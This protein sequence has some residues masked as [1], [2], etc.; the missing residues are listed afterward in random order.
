MVEKLQQKQT[1]TIDA[2]ERKMS[3][4]DIDVRIAPL[5]EKLD[6]LRQEVNDLLLTL[7]D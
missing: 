5:Q 3:S 6:I 4:K 2:Y 7:D 1:A